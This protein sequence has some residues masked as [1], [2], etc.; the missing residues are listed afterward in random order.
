MKL[1]T[2]TI[3]SPWTLQSKADLN[4][5]TF[6]NNMVISIIT[7]LFLFLYT[8]VYRLQISI[9]ANFEDS[10]EEWKLL[11]MS[12]QRKGA[13]LRLRKCAFCRTTREKECGQ[14]LVSDNQKVAAHHKC[15]VSGQSTKRD[16][17]QK[18]VHI[19]LVTEIELTNIWQWFLWK[20]VPDL[21]L[22]NCHLYLEVMSVTADDQ[23]GK[24]TERSMCFWFSR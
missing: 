8:S 15:M 20:H 10:T 19:N 17:F 4:W 23:E 21:F 22:R 2:K 5:I 6:V 1:T 13:S 18:L 24:C 11:A 12:G 3:C 16:L 14:L 7:I 9:F